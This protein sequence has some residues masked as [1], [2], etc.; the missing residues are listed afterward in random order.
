MK[1]LYRSSIIYWSGKSLGHTHQCSGLTFDSEITW[2]RLAGPL[3]FFPTFHSDSVYLGSSN[4]SLVNSWRL[5]FCSLISLPC[6]FKGD[7]V[8]WHFERILISKTPLVLCS[9]KFGVFYSLAFFFGF[10]L[11]HLYFD[12]SL[13]GQ[14]ASIF[15]LLILFQIFVCLVFEYPSNS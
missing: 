8:R 1:R 12:N 15:L 6:H 9:V 13:R 3:W 14:S 11:L 10:L 5:Y 7:F 4:V 2:G